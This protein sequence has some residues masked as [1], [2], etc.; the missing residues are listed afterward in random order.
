MLTSLL[1]LRRSTL[2]DIA[3]VPVVHRRIL[4]FQSFSKTKPRSSLKLTYLSILH[5]SLFRKIQ[6]YEPLR[7]EMEVQ[8]LLPDQLEV[9]RRLEMVI[10]AQGKYLQ[11]II[12]E[13]HKLEAL[14]HDEIEASESAPPPDSSEE[15]WSLD[16]GLSDDQKHDII[17]Q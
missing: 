15:T 2:V 14:N 11:K 9:L 12:E 13:Q 10:E 8:N 5:N 4:S 16:D 7:T 1:L 3:T 6:I 17:G